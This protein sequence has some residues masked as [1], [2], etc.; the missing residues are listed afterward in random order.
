MTPTER[1]YAQ[2]GPLGTV[3]VVTTVLL[4]AAIVAILAAA[5]RGRR[6]ALAYAAA[7]TVL[8]C[9]ALVM[10]AAST[11]AEPF[12]SISA[13]YTL[14]TGSPIGMFAWL[15]AGAALAGFLAS[16]RPA[17]PRLPGLGWALAAAGVAVAVAAVIDAGAGADRARDLYGPAAAL[18]DR[19]VQIVPAGTAVRVES[20]G[21]TEGFAER[22]DFQI[23]IAYALRR[24]GADPVVPRV[25]P[26]LGDR[27]DDGRRVSSVIRVA[28][29]TEPPAPG[30]TVL[31]RIP[32][33]DP[34]GREL[35][36]TS[37]PAD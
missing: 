19:L 17:R 32:V 6:S 4:L 16:R 37:R 3:S 35:L 22:F 9:G 24:H 8:L 30:A 27:Y 28:D 7:G 25:G 34:P 23:F 12:L 13:G 21:G 10:V 1:V 29:S 15:V 33:S 31:A 18:E 11:P 2:A 14:W 20:G 26:A 5:L 36:V